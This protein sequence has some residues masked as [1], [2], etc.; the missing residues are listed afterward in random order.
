MDE[1]QTLEYRFRCQISLFSVSRRTVKADGVLGECVN[2]EEP[3][4]IVKAG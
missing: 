2:E 3:L 4:D 1:S